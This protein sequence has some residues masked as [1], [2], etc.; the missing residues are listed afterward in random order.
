MCFYGFAISSNYNYTPSDRIGTD[1]IEH[2]A[3]RESRF[4]YCVALVHQRNRSKLG[5]FCHGDLIRSKCSVEKHNSRESRRRCTRL[6][7]ELLIVMQRNCVP[8]VAN[9]AIGILGGTTN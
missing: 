7:H 9:F 2:K 8:S 4:N 6:L 1:I 3:Q 5:S